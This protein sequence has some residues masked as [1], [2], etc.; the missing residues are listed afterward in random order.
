M[1][2]CITQLKGLIIDIDSFESNFHEWISLSQAYKCCFLTVSESIANELQGMF[3]EESVLTLKKFEKLFAPNHSTHEKVLKQMKLLTTEVVY[4]SKNI[5]FITNAL[6]FM[7]GTILIKRVFNRISRS[8]PVPR[9]SM[10]FHKR[11]GNDH[12][13]K[14]QGELW[15]GSHIS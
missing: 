15:R 2:E 7:S 12:K 14:Y 9:F 8:K 11:I 10:W 1:F 5:S 6:G 13:E 4:I 3:G